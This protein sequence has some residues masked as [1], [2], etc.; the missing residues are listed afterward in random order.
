MTPRTP[1]AGPGSSFKGAALYY[2]HDKQ[3]EFDK[4]AGNPVLTEERVEWT[5]TLNLSTDDPEK[6]WRIMAATA[7]SQ[8]ELNIAAGLKPS[9]ACTAPVYAYSLSWDPTDQVDRAEMERAAKESLEVLGFSDRQVMLVAHNDTA[10]PHV[11]IIVNRVHPE[12]GRS[13]HAVPKIDLNGVKYPPRKH[14]LGNDQL[15]LSRWAEAYQNQRGQHDLTPNRTKNNAARAKGQ[16]VKDTVSKN[17]HDYEQSQSGKASLWKQHKEHL[18]QA[19]AQRQAEAANLAA[20]HR[21]ERAALF[22]QKEAQITAARQQIH[23][24]RKPRWAGLFR[25]QEFEKKELTK[26]STGTLSRLL[27][28]PEKREAAQKVL[29]AKHEEQRETLK[30]AIQT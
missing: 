25:A 28:T 20:A 10:H 17:R 29:E 23:E 30:K 27:S 16:F 15:A 14:E 4:A 13:N 18:K 1:E 12:T 2:L 3:S 7:N 5:G 11:H 26:K 9:K 8:R 24:D 22:D 19:Y 6:A 21:G